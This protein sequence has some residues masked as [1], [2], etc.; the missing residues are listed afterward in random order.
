MDPIPA[1]EIKD[2][3]NN[4]HIIRLDRITAFYAAVNDD[5]DWELRINLFGCDPFHVVVMEDEEQME[6]AISKLQS[7]FTVV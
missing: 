2:K 5:S 7:C 1:I 4:S 6:S 3:D